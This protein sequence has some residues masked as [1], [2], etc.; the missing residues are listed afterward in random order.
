MCISKLV[1]TLV[2]AAAMA[3]LG[4]AATAHADEGTIIGRVAH[5]GGDSAVRVCFNRD[6]EVK[7]GEELAVVRHSLQPASPKATAVLE[8]AHVG[9][10]RIAAPGDDHCASAV[11]VSG[12]A[13]WLDW[14]SSGGGS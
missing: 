6:V 10:I 4:P 14:V 3:G 1:Y 5:G 12:S 11:V 7:P 8:S 2:I 13:K 9:V